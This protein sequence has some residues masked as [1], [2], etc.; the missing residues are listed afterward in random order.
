MLQGTLGLPRDLKGHLEAGS[1]QALRLTLHPGIETLVGLL[2]LR[3]VSKEYLSSTALM[4][5]P[6]WPVR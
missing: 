4:N 3:L 5:W 6:R 2:P 1:V